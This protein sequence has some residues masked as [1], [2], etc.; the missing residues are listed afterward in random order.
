MNAAWSTAAGIATDEL[1]GE[2][3]AAVH[4]VALFGRAMQCVERHSYRDSRAAGALHLAVGVGLAGG[5][6]VVLRRLVG[7]HAATAIAV[8]VASAGRM[9]DDEAGAV[10]ALAGRGDL[11]AARLRVPALVGRD[12]STLDEAGIARA[13][14]E[15]LAENSVDA[16][17]A[18]WWWGLVGGAPGALVHRAVNTL[19]A[20]VGHRDA[21]YRRFGW[22]SARLDDVMNFVPARLA[23]LAVAAVRP[24]RATGVWRT[25]RR[26]AGAHPSPNGGV[27]EA[28]YAAALGVRLGGI[29]RYGDLIENRGT[30]GDGPPAGLADVRRAVA[31][32][33]RSLALL[34]LAGAVVRAASGRRCARRRPGR[35][36]RSH[37]RAGRGRART[38]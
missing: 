25:V 13:V 11:D 28:A 36:R 14:V 3:P 24:R 10:A 34:V 2:P 7:R 9:L 32:R 21:R 17:V 15:S 20:M 30:L 35:R 16:V 22:A 29:N 33:R 8:A 26:H 4:P 5:T 23:A 27:I 38:R 37:R 1:L 18:T 6:A 31:L 19:D 12:S